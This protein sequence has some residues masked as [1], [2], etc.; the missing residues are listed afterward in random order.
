MKHYINNILFLWACVF[1]QSCSSDQNKNA[2]YNGLGNYES[3]YY[4]ID[5]EEMNSPLEADEYTVDS[6][7][8]LKSSDVQSEFEEDKFYVYNNKIYILDSN[9]AKTVMVFDI[10][11]NYLYK[12]GERGRAKNEYPYAP[13]DFFVA[14]NGNVHVFDMDG[15][16][17]LIFDNNGK[18]V[19]TIGTSIINSFGMTTNEK[20][21]YCIDNMY[22][23]DDES[24]PSLLIYD[25]KSDKKNCMI[26]SK[27]FTYH[28]YPRF[29][30]FFYNDAR[31]CHVPILADSIIVFKDDQVEKVVH[32]DFKNGFLAKE[33]PECV[34]DNK[35]NHSNTC[36][37]D[38][39][40]V[41]AIDEYQESDYY[42]YMRYIHKGYLKRWFYNH[43][44]RHGLKLFAGL[45]VFNDYQLKGNQVIAYVGKENVEMLKEY[46]ESEECDT[47]EYKKT[48]LHVKSFYRRKITAPALVYITIK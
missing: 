45:N 17:I 39:N 22:I 26:P 44:L 15:R 9:V 37:D 31:L 30:T 1:V 43:E 41:E 40:E 38:F 36:Y 48:P 21:L 29:R 18:F 5:P 13:T 34:R 46:C 25:S 7:R 11:G 14:R 12:L 24:D 23:S 4:K 10:C 33:R 8:S 32:F 16:R 19:R 27:H 35:N 47:N 6:I 20:Y 3:I 42:I 2:D 28:Y